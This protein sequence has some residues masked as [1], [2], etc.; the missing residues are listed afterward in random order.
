MRASIIILNFNGYEDTVECV[1]SLLLDGESD[2]E[3]IVWDNHSTRDEAALLVQDFGNQIRIHRSEENFGYAGGNNRAAKMASSDLLVFLNNDTVVTPGWLTRLLKPMTP[4]GRIVAC[5][6]KIRSYF[7]RER[8][9]YAGGCGGFVDAWGYTYTRG[10]VISVIEKDQ[11]QYDAPMDIDW[12]SGACFAIRKNAFISSGGFDE[13]FF[14]YSEEIDLCWRLRRSGMLIRSVPD[15]LI[16]HKGARVWR[17]K[18]HRFLYFKH[19]NNLL[20]IIKNLPLTELFFVL[21]L[22]LALEA[23][24]S[25]Y[26]F[27]YAG[28]TQALAPIR[29]VLVFLCFMP[30]YLSQRRGT[31]VRSHPER[32]MIDYF[33]R[34]RHTFASI[35]QR[36][37]Q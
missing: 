3:I 18:P 13:L 17:N 12:A 2:R 34:R 21:P 22:R 8:F 30:Y 1:R 19:R 26:Y 6:P 28:F 9:D 10:R 36:A 16:Y 14:A 31:F 15:S 4:E 27:R 23:A 11:G 24:A 25:V 32:I 7:D 33:C 37:S 35:T 29:A 20:M 5:Q